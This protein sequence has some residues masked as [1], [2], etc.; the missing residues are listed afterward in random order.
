MRMY[1]C[2]AASCF[3]GSCLVTLADG[4]KKRVDLIHPGDYVLCPSSTRRPSSEP[5]IAQVQSILR[6]FSSSD[7][8]MDLIS[9][10]NGLLVTPWHPIKSPNSQQ[11]TFPAL[12]HDLQIKEE[13][14]SDLTASPAVA[15]PAAAFA[16]PQLL[17]MKTKAVYSFLLGPELNFQTF[18]RI[19]T[20]GDP[21]SDMN[22]GQSML[23]NET[24]C[25][26]LAHGISNDPVASH[27][28]YG[29]EAVV[30][31]MEK[32]GISQE[33]YVDIFKGDI[34]KDPKTNLVIGFRMSDSE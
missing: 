11:W 6:S 33:G 30:S 5:I 28:F 16:K 31:A 27:S 18:Q 10:P 26:T 25:I 14:S 22:R 20:S 29:T 23:I 13:N 9:F 21:K 34:V 32:K 19:K 24:E 12:L 2:A 17:S 15:S 7:G 3:D 8:S 1:H 4:T